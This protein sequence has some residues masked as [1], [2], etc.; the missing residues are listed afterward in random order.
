[1]DPK[2]S[3]FSSLSFGLLAQSSFGPFA[4]LCRFRA[5]LNLYGDAVS[6]HHESSVVAKDQGTF[7]FSRI[8]DQANLS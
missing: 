5:C 3:V 4:V 6:I 2:S 8:Q 1:M 7:R